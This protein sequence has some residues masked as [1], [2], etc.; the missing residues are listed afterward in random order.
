MPARSAPLPPDTRWPLFFYNLLFPFV[1]LALLPGFLNRMFRRG[2]FREHFGQRL[3]FYSAEVR[4]RFAEGRWIWVHSISVG[5]TLVALKLARALHAA[6]PACRIVLS[7]T[8]STGYALVKDAATDWLSPLYNP[9]DLLPIVHRAYE[10]LKPERLVLI[11]GEAWP[12][13]VAEAWKRGIP[14]TLASA[15]LSP[16]SARRFRRFRGIAGP[17]FRMLE[18]IALSEP[19]DVARWQSLGVPEPQLRVTGNIKFDNAGPGSGSRAEEFRAL[20]A[21]VG[22]ENA[23]IVVAGSTFEG[24]ERLLA[25]ALLALRQ[26][27]PS[28][29]LILAPRHVE[30][31]PAILRDLAPLPLQIVRRSAL[32]TA[33]PQPCDILLIDT[34]GELRDWYHLGDVVFIGKSLTATGGQNPAEAAVIGKPVLF[35]P[36][37]ENFATLTAHLLERGAAIQVADAATLV[38]ELRRLFADPELR[39]AIGAKGRDA[40]A[41]HH[42]ATERTV[43]LLRNAVPK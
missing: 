39:T 43:E 33:T 35:G 42:G 23:P 34:T 1:F 5:E 17:I 15:R 32:P 12:N 30:R 29:V 19:A 2:G 37:M 40:L 8:T 27:V 3:G 38:N 14:A 21:T 18:G 24:E 25:E 10:V 36:H 41:A 7:T 13:L 22:L 9:V 20:A 6:D 26:A 11:E 4:Q 16:R 31:I 28:V